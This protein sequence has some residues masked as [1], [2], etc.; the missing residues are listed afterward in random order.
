MSLVW[1]C[2]LSK[3]LISPFSGSFLTPINAIII[4]SWVRSHFIT[5]IFKNWNKN[6]DGTRIAWISTSHSSSNTKHWESQVQ[7]MR[8]LSKKKWQQVQQFL[9]RMWRSLSALTTVRNLFCSIHAAKVKQND[10]IMCKT[11]NSYTCRKGSYFVL[12]FVI[13]THVLFVI[14]LHIPA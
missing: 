7:T 9:C 13:I 14:L 12:I 11:L 3:K 1:I 8:I 5:S 6:K 10:P 2:L 4:A